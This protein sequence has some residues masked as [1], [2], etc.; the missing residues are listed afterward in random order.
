MIDG[1]ND[2][3]MHAI[4]LARKAISCGAHINLIPLNH[5]EEREFKPSTAENLKN[6]VK[7][8]D[9]NGANSTVRRKLGGDVDASCGQ[10]RRNVAKNAN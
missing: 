3:P 7:I 4:L 5:V 9:E 8:L 1:V 2:T 10:L 6:F